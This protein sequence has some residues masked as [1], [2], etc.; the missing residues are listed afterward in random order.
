MRL[1]A[2]RPGH[3]RRGPRGLRLEQ[4]RPAAPA[5][6]FGG[7]PVRG[8]AAVGGPPEDRGEREDGEKQQEYEDFHGGSTFPKVWVFLCGLPPVRTGRL[9]LVSAVHPGEPSGSNAIDP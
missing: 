9:Y 2:F 8:V 4:P 6:A 5:T 3:S 7:L 1:L